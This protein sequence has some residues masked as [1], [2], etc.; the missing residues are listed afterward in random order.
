[1]GLTA[2]VSS[3]ASSASS[4]ASTAASSVISLTSPVDVGIGGVFVA[5]ALIALLAYY[6]VFNARVEIDETVRRTLLATII[7][8]AVAFGGVITFHTLAV[9]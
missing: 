9:L 6:D 8:L 3:S 7:P 1:M 2:M 5:V 4:S